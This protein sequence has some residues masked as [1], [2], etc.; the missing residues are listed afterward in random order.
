MVLCR[1]IFIWLNINEIP[2]PACLTLLVSFPQC[3]N[4]QVALC[5]LLG[6][7][8]PW[9]HPIHIPHIWFCDRMI[10]FPI[11]SGVGLD[12]KRKWKAGRFFPAEPF[13]DVFNISLQSSRRMGPSS[14]HLL[15]VP[16]RRKTRSPWFAFRDTLTPQGTLCW[17]SVWLTNCALTCWRIPRL[18]QGLLDPSLFKKQIHVHF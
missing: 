7:S 4:K 8:E 6:S 15:R 5:I 3:S 11:V 14:G 1:E 9:E 12:V 18:A 13:C 17:G 16:G 10:V 2:S